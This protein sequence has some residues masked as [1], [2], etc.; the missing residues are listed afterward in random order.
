MELDPATCYASLLAKDRRFDGWFYVGVSSTGIY[1]RPVCAVRA[2][3]QRNCHFFNTAAAAEHAGFRPCLRCRPELAPARR[4]LS[5]SSGTD[6]FLTS[7]IPDAAA[8]LIAEG[9]LNQH[10]VDALA[11]R[12]GVT[13]RHLLR[14]FQASY[15]VSIVAFAQTQRLLLAKRLLTDTALPVTAIAHAAGFGS[16]RRFNDLFQQ[17]YGLSPGRLRKHAPDDANG[18]PSAGGRAARAE[19]APPLVLPL[20]YRP[21]Y[22][23]DHVLAFLR[24]RVIAGVEFADDDSYARVLSWPVPTGTAMAAQQ[25]VAEAETPPGRVAMRDGWFRVTHAPRNNAIVVQIS[26]SLTPVLAQVLPCIRRLFD[27]DA[28][29]DRIDAHLG[30]LADGL[31]GIRVPGAVDGFEMGVRAVLGQ[32]VSVT[33]CVAKLGRFAATFGRPLADDP[34]RPTAL[35]RTFPDAAAFDDAL[36]NLSLD[37]IADRLCPIGMTRMRARAIVGLAQ[38]LSEGRVTLRPL[39][40]SGATLD[41]TL[42]ALQ[43]LPGIGAWTAQYLAMRVLGWPNAWPEADGVLLKQTG[44]TSATALR[45]HAARWEPWRAYAVMHLWRLAGDGVADKGAVRQTQT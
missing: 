2:P 4:A 38:A 27:L 6:A 45:A 33:Q 41:D 44:C 5:E 37:A 32:Q 12:M 9:F 20:V 29:P 14:L 28:Q 16:V 36:R 13:P 26:A 30:S 3:Q 43:A 40:V 15:G 25:G 11:G 7:H 39:A 31:R 34:Y 22:A 1:C 42:A 23:W 35:T 19:A 10:D 8:A 17:R 24:R 21:P 18:A